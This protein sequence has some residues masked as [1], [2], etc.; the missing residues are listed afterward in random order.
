MLS[1]QTFQAMANEITR[2]NSAPSTPVMEPTTDAVDPRDPRS[3]PIP[4]ASV[5]A[6][7]V[8]EYTWVLM[9]SINQ[10]LLM[11]RTVNIGLAT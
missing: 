1:R 7:L 10:K 3:M 9:V 8:V 2:S 11:T 5:G 4:S 6:S